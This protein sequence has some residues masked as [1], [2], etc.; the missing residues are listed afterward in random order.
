MSSAP[1]LPTALSDYWE[2]LIGSLSSARELA[3]SQ[4]PAAQCQYKRYHD[5]GTK[6]TNLK[7]GDW[8]LTRFPLGKLEQGRSYHILSMVP[9]GSPALTTRMPLPSRCTSR[10]KMHCKSTSPECAWPPVTSQLVTTT[11]MGDLAVGLTGP[12][13]GL[14]LRRY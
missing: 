5:Q 7:V 6:E 2:Q 10:R 14:T 11:G 13:S 4:V 12:L 1:L 9:I 8:V 3:A